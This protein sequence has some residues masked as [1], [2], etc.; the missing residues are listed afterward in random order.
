[1]DRATDTEAVEANDV[2]QLNTEEHTIVDDTVNAAVEYAGEEHAVEQVID[3]FCS[4]ADYIKNILTDE[5][6]VTF[7]LILK[8]IDDIEVFKS[9][10]R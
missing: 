8:D 6:S 2:V 1:V 9:K 4:S 5:N 7:R 10:V 3:E